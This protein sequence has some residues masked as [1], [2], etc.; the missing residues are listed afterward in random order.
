M[1][2][3]LLLFCLLSPLLTAQRARDGE[4]PDRGDPRPAPRLEAE[5]DRPFPPRERMLPPRPPVRMATP[6]RGPRQG[7][8][9]GP[10]RD[11]FR[12]EAP[13]QERGPGRAGALRE[14]L[15]RAR[16]HR[17]ERRLEQLERGRPERR[18]DGDAPRGAGRRGPRPESAP[19][20]RER[21]PR[22]GEPTEPA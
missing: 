7:R 19:E 1:K 9:P 13:G 3:L 2:R 17:L 22:R 21:Q 5:R 4:R 16:I 15:L 14:R 8:E 18:G 20:R 11:R 10:R 6:E 12:R